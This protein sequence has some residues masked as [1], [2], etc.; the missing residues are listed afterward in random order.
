MTS[1]SDLTSLALKEWA[2]AVTA[3]TQGETLLLLRKGG[4]QERGFSL[5]ASQFWLYPT[6]EHQKPQWLKPAYAGQVTPVESGWHPEWVAISAWASVTHTFQV[7]QPAEI[8]ALL[9][10]HVW[11]ES[12]VTERLNWMPQRPLLVLCLRVH[13]LA[14]PQIIP[15]RPEYGG[16]KSWIQLADLPS[17]EAQPV[18]TEADYQAKISAIEAVLQQ[19][20]NFLSI[21]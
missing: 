10:F 13:R 4:I 20:S 6:Y 3:L 8:E 9:P 15:Y 5:A 18:F 14:Q 1:S 7:D 11:T 17:S 19:P 21:Q 16:C 2:V 12:F